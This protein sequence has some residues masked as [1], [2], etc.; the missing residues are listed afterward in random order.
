MMSQMNYKWNFE[1]KFNLHEK[2]GLIILLWLS[3][4]LM[5]KFTRI[6]QTEISLIHLLHES[7]RA[8]DDLFN[9]T[10]ISNI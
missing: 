2:T 8:M 3:S 4:K 7:Y 9:Q 1:S 10:Q 5:T 6:K